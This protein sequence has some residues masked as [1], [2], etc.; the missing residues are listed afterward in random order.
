MPIQSGIYTHA[1]ILRHIAKDT[2]TYWDT[3]TVLVT[4]TDEDTYTVGGTYMDRDTCTDEDICIGTRIH[5]N[6]R[7]I[8]DQ[9]YQKN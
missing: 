7:Y 5:T 3:F 9:G 4:Y 1:G 2:S 6:L 8:H